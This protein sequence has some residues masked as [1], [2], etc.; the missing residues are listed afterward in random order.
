MAET[1]SNESIAIVPARGGSKRIPRKNSKEFLGVPIISRVIKTLLESNLFA[2]V[3]VSTDDEQIAELS[4]KAGASVPFR[5]DASL[6]GDHVSIVEVVT[7][8]L[9]RIG[10]LRGEPVHTSCVVYPTSVFVDRTILELGRSM[11][12]SGRFDLVFAGARFPAT[13][14]RAWAR[15]SENSELVR[16]INPNYLD[17]RTQDLP[18]SFYDLGQMYWSGLGGWSGFRNLRDTR[19]G[20]VEMSGDLA[21]DIDTEEDWVKA[22]NRFPRWSE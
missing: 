10:D 22:E 11:I 6:A 9:H 17:V 8:A 21:V 7:D 18:D 15:T 16:F 3:V 1:V 14:F 4:V 5:R 19:F 13:P 12:L 2:D 20:V